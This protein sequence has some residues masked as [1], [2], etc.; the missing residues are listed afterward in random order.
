[1]K[2]KKNVPFSSIWQTLKPFIAPYQWSYIGAILMVVVTCIVLAINP[3][4]EGQITTTL[5]ADIA[6]AH[7]L[8]L[9]VFYK[10]RCPD[11]RNGLVNQCDS[12]RDA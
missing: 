1:M 12:K 4:M 6:L 11:Y 7:H 5:L 8:I 10:N 2:N 3:S 9:S